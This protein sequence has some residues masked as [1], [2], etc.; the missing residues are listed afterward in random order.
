MTAPLRRFATRRPACAGLALALSVALF[1]GCSGPGGDPVLTFD[2]LD[3][4]ERL[5]VQRMVTLERA[6]AVAL[7]DRE[8]GVALLDSLSAAWGDSSLAETIAGLPRDPRRSAAVG[9]L[10]TALLK[11]DQDSLVLAPRAD[12]LTAPLPT[13]S[14]D[15]LAAPQPER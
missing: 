5:Y 10:L 6:K 2:D 9:R 3:A 4:G 8:R 15:D 11:A 13:P 1:P 12:R 14:P 7:V